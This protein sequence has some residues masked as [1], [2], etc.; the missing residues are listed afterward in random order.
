MSNAKF[1]EEIAAFV[2]KY[3][4]QYG[5]AVHSPI[6]AQAILESASGTSYKATFGHNY[7]GLK[8][9]P[10]RVS[11]ACGKFVDKSKEDRGNH[12]EEIIDYWFKFANME[13]G[14]RGYLQFINTS[15]YANLKG[16]TDPQEYLEKIKAD[17]YATDK[18]YVSKVMNVIKKYDLTKYDTEGK[19]MNKNKITVFLSAGHGGSD[20]GAVAYGMKEKDINLQTMLSCKEVLEGHGINVICSRTKDENDP[21]REEVKEAN[22][23]GADLAASFHVN[24]AGA[25]GFEAFCNLKNADGVAICKLAE[26]YVKELGQNSRGIKSGMHLYFVKNTKATAV[27]FESFFIDNDID[28]NIGDTIAEQKAF[29]VAY[30]RAILEHFG[31]KYNGA[32]AANKPTAAQPQEKP[33]TDSTA[34]RVKITASALNVRKSANTKADI[35][36]L[37]TDDKTLIAKNPKYYFPKTIYT[38]VET[39]GDWGKLKSGV[40]WINL[41]YTENV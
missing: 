13:D 15:N 8:Y 22:A 33:K 2:Q 37:I 29:G 19:S 9:R 31:V 7:F 24:A 18:N 1:I 12:D 40:G 35:V 3:A 30:A 32:Q 21:V 36:G 17:K 25:D 27:L 28:N 5:I 38:I 16:V 10:N 14:V 39:S 41:K 23:S 20:P 11:V 26:K 34:R 6:I 4:P